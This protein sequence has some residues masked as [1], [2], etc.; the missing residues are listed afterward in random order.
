MNE[1]SEAYKSL[2]VNVMGYVLVCAFGRV[3]C[4]IDTKFSE[5]LLASMRLRTTEL[6]LI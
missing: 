1:L 2:E 6:E 5:E 3:S 4:L